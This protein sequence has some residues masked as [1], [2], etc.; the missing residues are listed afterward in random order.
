M[1]ADKQILIIGCFDT[2]GDDFSFLY[3]RIKSH[4]HS[5]LTINTG[6]MQT[7]VSF[8]VDFTAEMVAMKAGHTISGLRDKMDRG[9]AVEVMGRGA[10]MIVKEL[11]EAQKVSAA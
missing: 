4:G 10:A 3:E 1:P 2:K 9:F 8:P 5:I 6:V 11:L 7:E